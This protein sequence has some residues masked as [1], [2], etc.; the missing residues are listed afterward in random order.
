VTNIGKANIKSEAYGYAI[1]DA[2]KAIEL[3]P[4]FVKVR[5]SH[6]GDNI[7]PWGPFLLLVANISQA[8]YR[9]AVAY[10]AILKSRDALKDFKT[11]VR[12][13]PNDKDAK[14]KLAECE[15]I[16]KRVEFFRAI[17][18][19]DEPSAAEG[20]D[21]DSMVV[22]A[23]YDGA[24]LGNEMTSEFIGDMLERF[25]NGK[26]LHK[27]YVYQII[28]AVQKIVYDEATMVEMEID[29]NVNLT[30]CGDTHGQWTLVDKLPTN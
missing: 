22:D 20:L 28:L 8:Y 12:K 24:R 3:D 30:V 27:K 9:R 14:L 23:D 26:K 21:L 17:E 16:V 11:V 7:F 29:D 10:T 25:K 13:A 4:N 15:K 19:G 5:Y 2:T 6:W 1:A 18:V